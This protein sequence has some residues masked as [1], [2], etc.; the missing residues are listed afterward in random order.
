LISAGNLL[1]NSFKEIGIDLKLH[2][3]DSAQMIDANLAGDMDLYLWG[4]GFDCDPDFALS[5]FTTDQIGA[6]SD[7][8]YSDKTYDALYLK[9][10]TSAD[11]QERH[12]TI[13]E[14]QKHLYNQSPYVMLAYSSNIVAHR[15]DTFTGWGDVS[16]YPGWDVYWWKYAADLVPV[17]ATTTTATTETGV[18]TQTTTPSPGIDTYT[19]GIAIVVIIAVAALAILLRRRKKEPTEKEEP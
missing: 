15:T 7:C 5:V 2:V 3:V 17:T 8:F 19:A 14:M 10:H 18:T 1:V 4:W 16:K 6:W 13:V 9:Q 12:S 11:V